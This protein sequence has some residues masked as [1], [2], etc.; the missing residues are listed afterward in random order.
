MKQP[1]TTAPMCAC[2]CNKRIPPQPH[3]RYRQ[4][5]FIDGHFQRFSHRHTPKASDIPSGLCECGC[6]KR[7]D[8]AVSTYRHNR[9][10]KGHPMPYLPGHSPKRSGP[11]SHKFKTGRLVHPS[12]YV[13]LLATGH[14]NRNASG[15]VYE[16]RLVMETK[17]GRLLTRT[18]RVHHIN[19]DKADNR[20]ENLEL[21]SGTHG[22]GVCLKCE[23]CGSTRVVPC[24]I[25]PGAPRWLRH[26]IPVKPLAR[27]R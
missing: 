18:E 15:Y 4:P 17:L 10:F 22:P 13:Y 6:G 3:H 1:R 2:G 19:G 16:H 26:R 23:E 12:G 11:S 5:K 20:P 21:T 27:S 24:D 8:L 9:H 25:I 7:T 14:P